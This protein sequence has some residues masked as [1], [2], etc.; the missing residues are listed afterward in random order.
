[1]IGGR[2][3]RLLLGLLCPLLLCLP[4][5]G[6]WDRRE[7]NELALT[8]ALGIDKS[9]DQYTLSAQVVVPA[10]I[11]AKAS[12]SGASP[13]T[14][15]QESAPTVFEALRKMTI[16][17]PRRVYLAHLRILVFG[18]QLAREGVGDVLDFFNREPRVR[19]NFFVMVAKG[20]EAQEALKITTSL[21]RIP[22]NKLYNS[23][24]QSTGYYSPT[25]TVDMRELINRVIQSGRE[26]VLTGLMLEGDEKLGEDVKNISKV[27]PPARLSY[28]NLAV[29]RKD[30]L[31]G[32]LG[33]DESKGYNYITDQIQ[34]S[35][36]HIK[37]DGGKTLLETTN[38]STRISVSE[39][40]GKPVIDIHVKN[41]E[42]VD[43][44][45]SSADVTEMEILHK[46]ERE[47]EEKIIQLMNAA[48]E[49]EKHRLH[50]DFL[51]F[52]EE[53]ARHKPRL[54]KTLKNGW[55]GRLEG[56]E[57]HCHVKVHINR[58]GTSGHSVKQFMEEE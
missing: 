30:K 48:I 21:E 12:S 51:G 58:I 14:L 49:A 44:N 37:V 38:S 52:G 6:C 5:S 13:V 15:Y 19:G 8:L 22:A 56:L 28:H 18:E 33:E 29:F 54:W 10:E 50:S 7:L 34:N 16:G 25:S 40:N 42:N 24:N 2:L 32:W 55:N 36:G 26:A 20:M 57:V 9:G 27:L 23:L 17:S 53:I 3:R 45:S 47:S 46:I 43:D 39:K 11:T 4:L 35:V 31:V 41:A 1:M